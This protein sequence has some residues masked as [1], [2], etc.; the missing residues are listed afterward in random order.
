MPAVR[1]SLARW[2]NSA[3]ITSVGSRNAVTAS[4]ASASSAAAMPGP[5]AC[6]SA[7]LELARRTP[8][9]Q[10][11]RDTRPPAFA[12]AGRASVRVRE[13][14]PSGCSRGAERGADEIHREQDRERVHRVLGDLAQ[15]ANHQHFIADAEQAG[16]RQHSEVRRASP[17]RRMGGGSQRV[18]QTASARA[19][20]R[21]SWSR[22]KARR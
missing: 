13:R 3:P 9:T 19:R 14:P 20:R 17:A 21:R 10:R 2:L 1:A 7:T 22:C 12:A 8:G 5:I 15:H 6:S 16:G 11:R 18:A 4:A